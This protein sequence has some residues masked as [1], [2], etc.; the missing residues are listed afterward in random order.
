MPIVPTKEKEEAVEFPKVR[1]PRGL[2]EDLRWLAERRGQSLNATMV[3]LLTDAG[4]RA[5]LEIEAED[6]A[7]KRPKR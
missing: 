7:A 6:A 1:G 5:R 4:A 2:L 3:Y